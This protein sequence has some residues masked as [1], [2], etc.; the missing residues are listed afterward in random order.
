MR[1]GQVRLRAWFFGEDI[2]II[3][4]DLLRSWILVSIR[5]AGFCLRLK[6]CLINVFM[7]TMNA[8]H[9]GRGA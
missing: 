6:K 8:F 9:H 7:E 4:A 1:N 3:L 5:G 2:S